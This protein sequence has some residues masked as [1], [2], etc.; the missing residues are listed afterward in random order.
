MHPADPPG[1]VVGID[2]GGTKLLAIRL[3]S[4]GGVT[5]DPLQASPKDGPGVVEEVVAAARRLCGP[6]AIGAVGLGIPGLVDGS[7]SLPTCRG[8]WVRR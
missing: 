6:D 2:V 4:G 8:W 7:G 1:G 3:D 5:A